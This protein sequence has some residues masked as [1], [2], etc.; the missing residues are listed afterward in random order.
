MVH[1][2]VLIILNLNIECNNRTKHKCKW[3]CKVQLQ[4]VCLG[5]K[6]IN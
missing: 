3:V 1:C 2:V 6:I 5:K 4:V